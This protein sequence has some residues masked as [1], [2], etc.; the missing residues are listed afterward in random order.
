MDIKP[1]RELKPGTLIEISN[2]NDIFLYL[3]PHLV[4]YG[5][6][7]FPSRMASLYSVT[8]G[9]Y[10]TICWHPNEVSVWAR[11]QMYGWKIL[12]EPE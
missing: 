4:Y 6:D 8:E 3:G 9:T 1:V 12:F 5:S 11:E 10:C 2:A 7:P